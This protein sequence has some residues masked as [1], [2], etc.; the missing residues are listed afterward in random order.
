MTTEAGNINLSR[1]RRW[2]I[3][4]GL[5]L[6]ITATGTY[7]LG[8]NVEKMFGASEPQALAAKMQPASTFPLGSFGNYELQLSYPPE[9]QEKGAAV[10]VLIF[11]N[12]N[13][14]TT[15]LGVDSTLVQ[16]DNCASIPVALQQQG[17][18][19][20]GQ[21]EMFGWAISTKE[22]GQCVVA[23]D[24]A[25]GSSPKPHEKINVDLRITVARINVKPRTD[26]AGILQPY[27]TA[28]LAAVIGVLTAAFTKPST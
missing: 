23:V 18:P 16:T 1:K 11:K 26:M 10:L 17:M 25:I 5:L 12:D 15:G 4:T 7:W 9:M 27:V 8:L 21:S 14:S 28:L 20:P 3:V 13:I 24:T 19:A 2:Y 6:V 22:P